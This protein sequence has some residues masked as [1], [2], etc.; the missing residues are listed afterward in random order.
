MEESRRPLPHKVRN[1]GIPMP[2]LEKL[3]TMERDAGH[4][5]FDLET[6]LNYKKLLRDWMQIIPETGE[7]KEI[8]KLVQD[9][10]EGM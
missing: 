7:G 3:A 6:W 4:E 9:Q 1:A 2:E 8:L 5:V 10:I